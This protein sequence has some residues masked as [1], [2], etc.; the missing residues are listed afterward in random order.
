MIYRRKSVYVL[1]YPK[2]RII[3]VSYGL[4]QGLQGYK[5]A[6]FCSTE[7]GS[8]GSPILSLNNFKVI[9]IHDGNVTDS[10]LNVG[11]FI[12]YALEKFI[13]HNVQRKFDNKSLIN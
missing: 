5:T 8:S 12:K 13:H 10:K 7:D 1:H 3:Q 11:I 4:S 6:Y 9:G 2:S